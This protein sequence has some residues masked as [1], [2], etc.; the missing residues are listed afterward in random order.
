MQRKSTERTCKTAVRAAKLGAT[1]QQSA[2]TS[3]SASA[4]ESRAVVI[5]VVPPLSLLFLKA[6]LV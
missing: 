6:L 3:S 1:T 5:A 4:K 2:V